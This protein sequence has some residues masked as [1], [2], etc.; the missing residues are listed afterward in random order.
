[1]DRP[2]WGD[3]RADWLGFNPGTYTYRRLPLSHRPRAVNPTRGGGLIV[4]WNN[5]EAP[6][7]R[8][9]PTEWSNGPVHHAM[10]LQNHVFAQARRTGGKV[11]LTQL[12]RAVNLSATTDLRGEDVYPWIR[13]VIGRV[14]GTDE[15]MLRIID[16]WVRSGSNRLDRNGDNVYEHSAAILASCNLPATMKQERANR[17][18]PDAV[19]AH[20][21]LMQPAAASP[22][23]S[24]AAKKPKKPRKKKAS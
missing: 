12:T 19:V 23:A 9:G 11:N 8:K 14:S 7:W 4:S 13:R 21:A 10:I 5:K 15:Q 20:Q 24:P 6:G 3:G 17:G 2:F 18:V 22:P 16:A 1:M